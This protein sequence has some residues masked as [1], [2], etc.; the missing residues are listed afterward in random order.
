MSRDEKNKYMQLI[1]DSFDTIKSYRKETSY[2]EHTLQYEL[3]EDYKI[4]LHHGLDQDD[5]KNF[6]ANKFNA[7]YAN[8]SERDKKAGISNPYERGYKEFEIGKDYSSSAKITSQAYNPGEIA[9][10]TPDKFDRVDMKDNKLVE[11]IPESVEYS[12]AM[13]FQELGIMNVSDFSMTT[14]GKGGLGGVDLMSAYGKNYE[15]WE[16]T[17]K[18]DKNFYTKFNDST[19]ITDKMTQMKN[20]RGSIYDLPLDKKMI[21]QERLRNFSLEQKEKMRIEHT[22]KVDTYYHNLNGGVLPPPRSM[23]K[24]N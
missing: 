12:N 9:I 8:N 2:P 1:K 22:N 17:I 6:N 3:G 16:D 4:N 13:N 5:A 7:V 21:E 18:R 23:P 24:L 19:K 14:S 10:K 11:Y 20:D 15:F